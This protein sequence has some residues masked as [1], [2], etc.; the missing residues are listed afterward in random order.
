MHG[1]VVWIKAAGIKVAGDTK[2]VDGGGRT[3][4]LVED[5]GRHLVYVG[6]GQIVAILCLECEGHG[7]ARV[8]LCT[9]RAEQLHAH[10]SEWLVHDGG[11]VEEL[12][13]LWS[14]GAKP[15]GDE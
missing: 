5:F 2:V 1:W 13:C 8:L 15:G 12:E 3:S 6:A 11:V 10:D 9:S 4:C 14:V 7:V